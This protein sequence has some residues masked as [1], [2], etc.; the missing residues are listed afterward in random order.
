MGNRGGVQSRLKNH[1]AAPFLE[2]NLK[3]LKLVFMRDQYQ[4]LAKQASKKHW[5]HVDYFEKLTDGEVA[6]RR[7]ISIFDRM[8]RPALARLVLNIF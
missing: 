7:D 5:S 4:D 8:N 6:L 3:Y 1:Y 2:Q